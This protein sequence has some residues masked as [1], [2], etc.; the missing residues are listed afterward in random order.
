MH[1]FNTVDVAIMAGRYPFLVVRD[2]QALI[3]FRLA[4]LR[5]TK[6]TGKIIVLFNTAKYVLQVLG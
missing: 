5:D 6:F 2:R 1:A 4:S 3:V